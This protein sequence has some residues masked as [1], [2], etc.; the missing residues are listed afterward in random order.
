MSPE[1]LALAVAVLILGSGWLRSERRWRKRVAGLESDLA[2]PHS[3]GSDALTGALTARSLFLELD[4]ELARARRNGSTLAVVALDLDGAAVSDALLRS[5]ASRI[6]DELREYDRVG[7]MAADEFV[8]LLPGATPVHVA[9]IRRRLESCVAA[10]CAEA[11]CEASAGI[12]TAMFPE[13]GP[14]AEQL[15]VQADADMFA[16]KQRRRRRCAQS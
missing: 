13:H 16:M 10:A 5:V 6:R 11:G 15:L 8:V 7:R 2:R 12:G 9:S 3:P 14:D 4:A 1:T